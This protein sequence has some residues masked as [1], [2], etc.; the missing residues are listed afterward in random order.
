M[1]SV[2]R[3]ACSCSARRSILD[4]SISASQCCMR[5]PCP[6]GSTAST[7][8]PARAKLAA[9]LY[10]LCLPA[11]WPGVSTIA[12]NGPEPDA[13][14]KTFAVTKKPGRLSYAIF[15]TRNP[16]PGTLPNSFTGTGPLCSGRPPI[17]LRILLRTSACRRSASAR[18]WIAATFCARSSACAIPMLFRYELSFWRA[19]VVCV[20][21][22][23]GKLTNKRAA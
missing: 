14:T 19:V 23:A 1:S 3:L 10:S 11:P 5:S 22:A 18:V 9:Q 16:S 6:M 17:K 20:C 15:S 12:G 2:E 13:G 21:A 8:I 4:D 7:M